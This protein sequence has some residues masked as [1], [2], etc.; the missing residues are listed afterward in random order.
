MKIRKL[1]IISAS[2][3]SLIIPGCASNKENSSSLGPRDVIQETDDDE[4]IELSNVI[5]FTGDLSMIVNPPFLKKVDLYNA[6]CINPVTY[7]ERD[8]KYCRDLNA[9]SLRVDLSA[10][11]ANGNGGRYLVSDDFKISEPD[12][13]GKY[14]VL[15]D[16]LKYNFGEFDQLVGYFKDIDV[17]PYMSWCYLPYPLQQNSNWKKF[18]DNVKN[19]QEVW[20]EVYYQ[21]AKHCL[22]NDI[23]IGYHEMFNEPDLETLHFWGDESIQGFLDWRD[24]CCSPDDYTKLDPSKGKYFD[25][26]KYGVTGV[27]RADPDAT[28]GGPAFAIGNI[29]AWGGLIDRI[30]SEK[31]PMDFFSF[32]SYMDGDTWYMSDEQRA[33]GKENELE[34]IVHNLVKKDNNVY[35]NYMTT[36]M[37]I[38]EFSPLNDYNGAKE[39]LNSPFNTYRGG[40]RTFTGLDEIVNRTS[41]QLVSWA[42]IMSVN[43]N[44]NDAYG[45]IDKNGNLKSS[46]NALKIYQDLPVWRYGISSDD[47]NSGIK[48]YLAS[49][50]DKVSIVLWNT[51]N[52][53]NESGGV[54]TEGD[55]NVRVNLKN[56]WLNNATRRVYRID[57]NHASSYDDTPNPELEAQN[58]RTYNSTDEKVWQGQIPAEGMVYIT[59][60]RGEN[61]DFDADTKACGFANDIKT[62]YWYED[63]ARGIR[64]NDEYYEDYANDI[65][66]SFEQFNRKTWTA[67]LGMG[68]CKGKHNGG[69]AINQGVALSAVTCDSLPTKFNISCQVEGNPTMVN[70]YSG[71][72]VRIDFYNAS[73][74]SYTKSVFFHDGIYSSKD[75][76]EQDPSILNY[77]GSGSYPFGTKVMNDENNVGVFVKAN[78][79]NEWEI[80]LSQY[81]PGSWLQSEQRAIVS[82]YMRNTGPNTRAMFQLKEAIQNEE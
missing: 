29:A 78:E 35:Q 75:Y 57:A 13:E 7:Y 52:S 33:K 40:S 53:Y 77:S 5:N 46:Y 82:F 8:A 9:N 58:I 49:D 34:Q 38:S 4:S 42:Q 23:K 62:E 30:A 55:R 65:H 22:D 45:I 70:D 25:M 10:G 79:N 20:E 56:C 63:R 48:A 64:G 21:Y 73:S 18:D 16:S 37:H 66:G 67:Y 69:G 59:I 31:L 26:Y 27:R 39:G 2:I 51:N 24:F 12:S 14:N 60:N 41:I 32:H 80:D 28:I 76:R 81:A 74:D 50:E 44:K 68:D 47:E 71:L 17:L 19:W 3:T 72:G 11:K 1:L 43:S 36:Q 15:L 54:S 6:G 61:K